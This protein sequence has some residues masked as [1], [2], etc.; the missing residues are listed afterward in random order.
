VIQAIAHS[1]AALKSKAGPDVKAIAYCWLFHLVGDIHQPLH[2]TALFSADHFPKGDKGG[3][4]IPLKRGRKLHSL[5][6]GLLG[7]DSKMRSVEKATDELS[8]KNRF[9]DIWQ[10]AANETS[11]VKWADESH[12]LCE[13]V[14]YD[15]L[16]LSAV[17]NT[18]TGGKIESIELPLTYYQNAGEVARK[19]V[20]TAGLR[21]AALLNSFHQ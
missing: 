17:R 1:I 19:R 16:I 9:A 11:P 8:L 20:L 18:P 7:S 21:L 10:S 13:S 15:K 3:N 5:W 2:S 4:E 12:A 6:D 14:V